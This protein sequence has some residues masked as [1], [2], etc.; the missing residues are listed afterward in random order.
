LQNTTSSVTSDSV[1][2]AQKNI[3]KERVIAYVF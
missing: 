3:R 2:G 1:D